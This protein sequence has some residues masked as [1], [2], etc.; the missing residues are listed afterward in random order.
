LQGLV[1]IATDG[2][3]W[4]Y[5]LLTVRRVRF[6]SIENGDLGVDGCRRSQFDVTGFNGQ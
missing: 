2:L 5:I 3:Q 1:I 6:N 4:I